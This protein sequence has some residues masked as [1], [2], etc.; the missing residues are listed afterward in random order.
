MLNP[1]EAIE[2]EVKKATDGIELRVRIAVLR[3]TAALNLSRL[4]TLDL[5]NAVQYQTALKAMGE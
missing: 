3:E 1:L 2:T 5:A 4:A